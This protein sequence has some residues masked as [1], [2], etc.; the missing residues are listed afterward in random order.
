MP[1]KWARFRQKRGMDKLGSGVPDMAKDVRQF[2]QNAN[3]RKQEQDYYNRSSLAFDRFESLDGVAAW[4][5]PQPRL[6]PRRPVLAGGPSDG[7]IWRGLDLQAGRHDRK[8]KFISFCLHAVAIGAILAWSLMAHTRVVQPETIVTP[9]NFTLYAPPPPP[10]K[11]MPVA[12]VQGGGGGGGAHHVVEPIHGRL[13]QVAPIHMLPPQIVRVSNPKLAM[14]PTMQ[15]NMPTNPAVPNLGMQQSPQIALASQGNG[16]G[17]GFGHG[18]GGGIGSSSGTGVGPGTGGGYG[19]GVMSVGGGVSAPVLVHSVDPEFT[20]EA[21]QQSFQGT[22]AI[23]LIVDAQG[24]P[25]AVHVAHHLGLGLDEKAIAAVRQ[26]RFRPAMYQGH[27][28]AVQ[29]IVEVDFRLH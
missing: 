17:S 5:N 21:R 23:Q 18:M 16:S 13:P 14:E 24:Y 28:V 19:G 12:K 1:E 22:V 2:A 4:P 20:E 15:V 7:L 9:L 27:P 11:V 25:Q 10:P 29:M 3:S 6:I 8:P 26:Y